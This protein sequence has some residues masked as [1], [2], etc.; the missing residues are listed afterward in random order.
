MIKKHL[1]QQ[2]TCNELF[3]QLLREYNLQQISFTESAKVHSLSTARDRCT[4]P[5]T[6]ETDLV[7]SWPGR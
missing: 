1:I 3:L 4:L 2:I 7:D 5:I 6:Y